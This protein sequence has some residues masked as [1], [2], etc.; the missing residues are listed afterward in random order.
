M[1]RT[2]EVTMCRECPYYKY[3]AEKD[4]IYCYHPEMISKRNKLPRRINLKYQWGDFP[5]MCP[6]SNTGGN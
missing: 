2:I 4:G 6:L 1:S 3:W 5:E